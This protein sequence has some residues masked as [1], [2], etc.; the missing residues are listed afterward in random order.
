MKLRKILSLAAAGAAAASL[1]VGASADNNAC[2]SFQTASYGFRNN[3]YQTQAYYWLDDEQTD[4]DTWEYTDAEITGNGQY[5]VSFEKDDADKAQ[6]WNSLRI[7]FAF[8]AEDQPDFQVT[9]DKLRIDGKDVE[10]TDETFLAEDG[11]YADDYTDPD[12]VD[13]FKTA[14]YYFLN[15][16]HTYDKDHPMAIKSDVYGQKVEAIF[17]VSGFAG[18]SDVE[19]TVAD[20][21][22]NPPAAPEAPEETEA[23]TEAANNNTSASDAAQTTAAPASSSNGGSGAVVWIIVGVVVVIAV[24]AAVVIMKKKK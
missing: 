2:L 17:T 16:C 20:E 1:A 19:A 24:V 13:G 11:A 15:I 5:Y 10:L 21:L 3:I 6:S 22:L 7:F 12:K 14:N 23:A 8:T 18:G 4:Y 9:L